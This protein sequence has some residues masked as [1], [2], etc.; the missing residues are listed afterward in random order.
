MISVQWI[1][2]QMRQHAEEFL[3][4]E[5]G[6][7]AATK[8]LGAIEII[9]IDAY[10]E[11]GL[12]E[13]TEDHIKIAA[14]RDIEAGKLTATTKLILRHELGHIFDPTPEEFTGFEEEIKHE[15][16]AWVKAKPKNA[17]ENW[18]KNLSIRTHIDPLKMQSL[19][20]PRPE[21]KL[22]GNQLRQGIASEVQRMKKYSPLVDE[23]L[24][25]RYAMANL[26]ENPNFYSHP[27][28]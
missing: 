24:A 12:T 22:S 10:D 25:K 19:G 20:F 13:V 4:T 18:Y 28:F 6:P 5:Y 27:K 7:E 26:V 15:R 14:K 23:T 3:R 8:V 11:G 1:Q 16:T 9:A 21:T 2:G 17:A